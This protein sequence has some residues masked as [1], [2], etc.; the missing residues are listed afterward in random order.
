[1]IA[2]TAKGA[3]VGYRP[4]RSI[5]LVRNPNWD[6]RTDERPAYVDE[7]VI[8]EG[9]SDTTL[10]ARK[11]LGGH[12]RVSGDF[13][14]PAPVIAEA[15]ERTP[16]QITLLP[17]GGIEYIPLN[18]AIEP[19]DD[20]NVRRAVVA[21]FDRNAIRLAMGG[22]SRGPLA[23]HFI[24]PQIPGFEHA[25]GLKGPGFDFLAHPSGDARLAAK[26]FRQAGHASGRYDGQTTLFVAS[27]ND[28][29]TERAAQV[30]QRNF[31]RLGFK[32]R[33]RVMSPDTFFTKFCT[34]PRAKVHACVGWGWFR[35]FSD[36]QTILGPTFSGHA[37]Q[38]QNN[39][40]VSQLDIPQINDAIRHAETLI[41]PEERA[42]A[43]AAVDRAV[44]AQAPAIPGS[45]INQA[46]VRSKDVAAVAN[47]SIAG[48]DLTYTSLR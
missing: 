16:G 15:R 45:W 44:T 10:A 23:T 28:A 47:A 39:S 33:L 37:I 21:G 13:T 12:H 9:N 41:A 31:E 5:N 2:N 19:F 43:W 22:A 20:V 11:V 34:S 27:V 8:D 48:W 32:V 3:A 6:A 36:G 30:A 1:M 29:A 42:R 17:I 25:G 26:Y 18:T 7:V 46:I 4:G 40:N 14:A 24:P 38:A 35:D